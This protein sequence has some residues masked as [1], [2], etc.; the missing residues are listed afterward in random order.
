MHT[1]SFQLLFTFCTKG[2]KNPSW[3][4]H[5]IN[6]SKSWQKHLLDAVGC[7]P[8][9]HPSMLLIQCMK[10]KSVLVVFKKN[11]CNPQ[12][13]EHLETL[14]SAHL[15]GKAESFHLQ[16]DL[17]TSKIRVSKPWSCRSNAQ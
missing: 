13:P 2:E 11:I 7:R 8:V 14:P 3:V 10:A 1:D 4:N 5:C 6:A 9:S 16:F 17:A 15:C 12:Q